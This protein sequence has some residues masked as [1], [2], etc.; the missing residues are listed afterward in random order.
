ML[1]ESELTSF[2]FRSK[3]ER[4]TGLANLKSGYTVRV[5]RS[6]HPSNHLSETQQPFSRLFARVSSFVI[7]CFLSSRHSLN[8]N[9]IPT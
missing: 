3:R 6:K 1:R 4:E 7:A 8:P 9:Y 2:F 5:V